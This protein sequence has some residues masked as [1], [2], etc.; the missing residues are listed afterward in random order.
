VNVNQRLTI[1]KP[2]NSMKIKERQ[3]FLEWHKQ[4][5]KENYLFDLKKRTL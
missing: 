4:K 2:V 1:L 3:E 5:R